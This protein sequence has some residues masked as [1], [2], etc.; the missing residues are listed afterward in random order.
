M[1]ILH[2]LRKLDDD[3]PLMAYHHPIC[4]FGSKYDFFS[5]FHENL[6]MDAHYNT[7]YGYCENNVFF[8]TRGGSNAIFFA[9]LATFI[10]FYQYG[11]Y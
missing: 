6:H 5:D 2:K 8:T 3:M 1:T 9:V 4:A 7:D 11:L 10:N